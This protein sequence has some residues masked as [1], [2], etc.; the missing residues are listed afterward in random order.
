MVRERLV[1]VHGEHTAGRGEPPGLRP[2]RVLLERVRRRCRHLW[3]LRQRPLRLR[4]LLLHMM[5]LVQRWVRVRGGC[6]RVGL[7]RQR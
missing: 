4:L 3:H 7:W 6:V 5:R 2:L 1:L